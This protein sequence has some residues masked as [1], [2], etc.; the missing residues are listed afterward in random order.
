LGLLQRLSKLIPLRLGPAP[1]AANEDWPFI[2]GKYTLLN[3]SGPVVV[4]SLADDALNENLAALAPPGLCMIAPLRS[5]ADAEKLV[6]NVVA[7]LSVQHLLVVGEET[8]TQPLGTALLALTRGG[9]ADLDETGTALLQ[10]LNK[11]FED[12]ELAALRKHV[13]PADL[14]GCAEVDKIIATIGALASA[15]KRPNTGFVAPPAEGDVDGVPRLIVAENS[16]YEWAPDK[17]GGFQIKIERETIV[18]E[19]RS[20]KEQLLRVVQGASA[21]DICLTLIRNGWVSKLDHAAYLGYELMRA[22]AALRQGADFAQD[23]RRPP[24]ELRSR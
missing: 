15:A 11:K 22:E 23:Q 2:A 17:A 16:A 14:L 12:D 10:A 24:A 19:H 13:A 21:R 18:V 6:R 7:N 4:A 5:V 8:Q 1:K 9:G 3:R 20:A